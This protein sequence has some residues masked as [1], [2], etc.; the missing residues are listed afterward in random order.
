MMVYYAIFIEI[1]ISM[2]FYS[3]IGQSNDF[4]F[5]T[6]LP[7]YRP[8][9]SKASDGYGYYMAIKIRVNSQVASKL[10]KF[11]ENGQIVWEKVLAIEK[12]DLLPVKL[13]SPPNDGVVLISHV[14][15][16]FHEKFAYVTKYDKNGHF[17]FAKNFKE[18]AQP[19]GI[20]CSDLNIYVF[21]SDIYENGLVLHLSNDG[22]LQTTK[23]LNEINMK[24]HIKDGIVLNNGN[25]ALI[26]DAFSN[27]H[28][29]YC[30]VAILDP[31]ISCVI[32]NDI[33]ESA[34]QSRCHAIS[35]INK[36]SLVVIGTTR[37]ENCEAILLK[38]KMN[39]I[40]D[41]K[42]CVSS[43]NFLKSS[44][45]QDEDYLMGNTWMK[46]ELSSFEF[47]LID[48][49]PNLNVKPP[50]A[51]LL[52]DVP[53]NS[54]MNGLTYISNQALEYIEETTEY[55]NSKGLR[56]LVA[57]EIRYYSPDGVN[58]ILCEPCYFCN[59][60]GKEPCG[61]GLV[62]PLAGEGNA[63]YCEA[64]YAAVDQCLPCVKC[65]PGTYTTENY[66]TACIDCP[67]GTYAQYEG[68]G[69]ACTKC[70]C[71][72]YSGITKL[73][74]VSMCYPCNSGYYSLDG[75]TSSGS[76][77][78]VQ[79]GYYLSASKCG[80]DPCPGG[81]YNP[82]TQRTSS[83]S[84]IQCASG[85][86][87]SPASTFCAQCPPGTYNTSPGSSTCIACVAGTYQPN[88]GSNYMS[89][90]QCPSGC[91]CPNANLANYIEC[92]A[93][94]YQPNTGQQTCLSCPIGTGTSG[95]RATVCIDCTPGTYASGG[96]C[97]N[98]PAGYK[99]PYSKM[100]AATPCDA[101]YYQDQTGKTS[102]IECPVGTFRSSSGGST[103]TPCSKGYYQPATKSTTCIGC[104]AGEYQDVT[105]QTECKICDPGYYSGANA[106][107]QTPCATGHFQD[108][109]KS[110]TCK[111]C[112]PGEYQDLTGQTSCK[113]CD[114]GSWSG[115]NYATCTPCA[116]GYYEDTP[117][118]TA[119]KACSIGYYQDT[120]GQI[121]CKI[122]P[123][124]R[125]TAV[126]ATQLCTPCSA[127]FFEDLEGSIGCR[128]CDAGTYT[129]ITG[130]TVC[131][132]CAVGTSQPLTGKNICPPCAAG[133]YQ[134][135]IMSTSCI[136]CE[137]GK[138]QPLTG[139]TSCDD[140]IAGKYQDV[141]G[142]ASCKSCPAGKY[143]DLTG[144]TDCK[145]CDPGSYSNLDA[146]TCT[147]CAA[148]YYQDQAGKSSCIICP[149]GTYQP[150]TGK[151]SCI[152]C[153]AGT[154]NSLTGRTAL[155][156]CTDCLAGTYSLEGAGTCTPCAT[157]YYQPDIGKTSCIECPVGKQRTTTGGAICSDCPAGYYADTI[158]TSNCK[159]CS[160]GTY[161]DLTGQ[162]GCKQCEVAKYQS[163]TGQSTCIVC[164]AGTYEDTLGSPLC[165]NCP[166]GQF[167]DQT[168][169]TAC[170]LC[171]VGYSQ[172]LTGKT[173]C[174][175]CAAG[176]Y[177]DLTGQ[178][179]CKP[180][181]AGKV[182]PL[183][184]QTSCDECPIAYY[185]DQTGKT[186]CVI[187]PAGKF[188]DQTGQA[189]CKDCSPGYY[190]G[191]GATICLICPI[192]TYTGAGVGS[193]IQCPQGTYNPLEGQGACAKCPAGQYNSNTGSIDVAD[194]Q[195]CGI[196]TYAPE[197][198]G[199]CIA[200]DPGTYQ[201]NTAQGSCLPCDA[202]Y[203]Q[204]LSGKTDCIIC[205]S[206]YKCPTTGVANAIPCPAGTYQPQTGKLSCIDCPAGKY[207]GTT[208]NTGCTDCAVG[209]YT[210]VIGQAT[211]KACPAGKY[212]DAT[213]QS[214][215]KD[216]DV[217]YYQNSEH[218][219]ACII[220][221]VGSYADTV[222][223]AN[224]KLCSAG[225]Y[226]DQTGKTSCTQCGIGYYQPD[227]GK[228]S[229]IVCSAG[230]YQDQ[231]GKESCTQCP[232]G[233][234]Q[235]LT[236]KSS[237]DLCPVAYYQDL[238]G[239]TA[240]K[241]CPAGQFQDLEGQSACKNC[242][243]GYTSLEG[244]TTCVKCLPGTY[245]A[246]GDGA[247]T[248]CPTGT[249]QTLDGQSSC[250]K[251]PAGTANPNQQSSSP[252]A[253][254][255]CLAGNYAPEASA[256]CLPCEAGTYQPDPAKGTCIDCEAGTYQDQTGK[257][258]CIDC[259]IGSKCPTK[260]INHTPCPAG[261]IQ[262]EAKKD[263]CID[264]PIGK[265]I[266][267]AGQTACQSC[268][269][270]Y[271]A[272][273]PGLAAC[274]ACDP[275]TFQDLQEQSTCNKC[276]LGKE[277]PLP[278]LTGCT[279][280]AVGYYADAEGT[281]TCKACPAGSYQDATGKSSCIPCTIGKSQPLT[282][283][284]S[285]SDCAIGY[286]QDEEGKAN[287]KACPAGKIQTL[288]GQSTCED[289]PVGYYQDLTGQTTCKICVAG[290]Y[291]DQPA[292]AIC[293]DCDP[294]YFNTGT[295]L[296]SCTKCSI[297]YYQ[298]LPG[299]TS[300]IICP[301]G[302]YGD[303]EGLPTCPPCP[304][305]TVQPLTGQQTCND[306]AAGSYA[307][308]GT[309]TCQTCPVG[310]AQPDPVK[311][312]CNDCPAGYYQDLTGQLTCKSCAIG[313][314]QPTPKQTTC[315]QCG[316]GTYTPAAGTPSCI[317][318]DAGSYQNQPGKSSCT[319]CLAGYY[320]ANA[321]SSS[322]TKCPLGKYSEAPGWTSCKVPD[323]GWIIKPNRDG[324]L[325]KGLFP[326][327]A[328]YTADPISK[329]C[330][331]SS[332][333]VIKP[334]TLSCKEAIRTLCCT[335]ATKKTGVDCNYA[336][337]TESLTDPMKDNYCKACPFMDQ[338]KC[339]VNGLCWDETT[340]TTNELSTYPLTFTQACIDA[341][342]SFCIP[343]FTANLN[344]VECSLFAAT[345][346][347]VIS[348]AA[349]TDGWTTFK[350]TISKKLPSVLPDC[351]TL[352]DTTFTPQLG[353]ISIACTR[354]TDSIIA[355]TIGDSESKVIKIK[356]SSNFKD[357][358]GVNIPAKELLITPASGSYEVLTVSGKILD[359]CVDATITSAITDKYYP[360]AIKEQYWD[361]QYLDNAGVPSETLSRF[362]TIGNFNKTEIT[363]PSQDLIPGKAIKIRSRLTNA[364]DYETVA[365]W[366]TI[367]IPLISE[368]RIHCGPCQLNDRTKCAYL[369]G[370]CWTNYNDISVTRPILSTDCKRLMAPICYPILLANKNDPQCKDFV[371]I[372]DLDAMKIKPLLLYVAFSTT[373]KSVI[374]KFNAQIKQTNPIDYSLAFD[375]ETLKW[376]PEPLTCTWLNSTSLAVRY[377]P[378]KGAM[379]KFTI[380][381]DSFFY[382]YE[383]AIQSVDTTTLRVHKPA[384][385]VDIDLQSLSDVSECDNIDVFAILKAATLYRLVFRWDI[386]Y[387]APV[388]DPLYVKAK[389]YFEKYRNYSS[390]S[391]I[392]I[393]SS[394]IRKDLNITIKM[395]AKAADVFSGEKLTTKIIRVHASVPK[396]KFLSKAASVL[397]IDG[398]K[399]TNMP[400]E[401]DSTKCG[402]AADT[403]TDLMNIVI[404]FSVA[405]G[406]DLGNINR[407]TNDELTLIKTLNNDFAS[408]HRIYVGIPKGFKYFKYYNIT[409]SVKDTQSNIANI[410]KI[411]IYF[412][413]PSIQAIITSPGYLINILQDVT[414]I[415]SN[416]IIPEQG[417]D[418]ITFS[419]KC[420]T[421]EPIQA[422]IVCTCPFFID[423][424]AKSKN[425]VID[426]AKLRS[427]CRYIFSLAL[428]A[429]S[430]E[431]VRYSNDQ[432]E[433]IAYDGPTEIIKDRIIEPFVTL[434]NETYLTF[435]PSSASNVLLDQIKYQWN[436]VEINSLSPA[437]T[438]NMT[439]KGN[440]T[441]AFFQS[442]GIAVD[443]SIKS[444]DTANI[445]SD[446]NMMIKF[447]GMTPK[448]LT[449]LNE[450]VLGLD[451]S[452][453]AALS[454]YTFGI[455][456]NGMSA[457]T[458][459]FM[460]ITT[461]PAPRQRVFTVTPQ[462]GI[463]F[464]TTFLLTWTMTST[465][466]VDN[467]EYQ[468]FTRNCP[469]SQ[470]TLS[471]LT[472]KIYQSNSFSTLLAP[473]FKTCNESVEI[474]L[475]V[476]EY[477]YFID[478]STTVQISEP[479]EPIQQILTSQIEK[480]T[481][482]KDLTV[483]Q[484]ITIMAG[485]SS[486]K[487]AEATTESQKVVQTIL[488]EI[489]DIGNQTT[490]LM[491]MQ[492]KDQ[493]EFLATSTEI[494]SNL[495]INEQINFDFDMA[496]SIGTQV[497]S[498]LTKVKTIESGTYI[499]PSAV[500]AL[501]GI[502][503]I[504]TRLQKQDNFTSSIQQA[505]NKISD[506]KLKEMI[507]GSIGF[508]AT[509]PSLE[510][511]VYKKFLQN[512]K[513][514]SL[515]LETVHGTNI[516]ISQNIV[517]FY[518]T[519]INS[520]IKGTPAIGASV[521]STMFNPYKNIKAN[522]KII[523]DSISAGLLPNI[524]NDT[525]KRIYD[526][527]RQGKLNDTINMEEIYMPVVQLKL[528]PFVKLNNGS[529]IE[530]NF[531]SPINDLPSGEQ[532]SFSILIPENTDNDV[533]SLQR[534]LLFGKN[535]KRITDDLNNTLMIPI[536]YEHKDEEW[537]NQ[538]CSM[539]PAQFGDTNLKMNCTHMGKKNI[540][541]NN[542]FSVTVDITKDVL[543]VI[544]KGNYEQLVNFAALTQWN[545]RTG[546]AYATVGVIAVIVITTLAALY[547]FD[548]NALYEIKRKCLLS[549]IMP[550]KPV[551][552]TSIFAKIMQF[553][554]KLRKKGTGNYAKQ[555]QKTVTADQKYAKK[556]SG[557]IRG[558]HSETNLISYIPEG[559]KRSDGFTKLNREEKQVLIDTLE[560][561]HQCIALYDEKETDEIM[562]NELTHNKVLNRVTNAYIDNMM[563][564]EEVTFWTIVKNEHEFLNAI[565]R[566]EL[567]TP[568]PS[569]FLIFVSII[570]GELFT[571]GYFFDSSTDTSIS[572][573]S[574]EFIGKA[575][576]MSIAA[577]VLMIPLK[578][579][580]SVFMTG[581]ELK[582]GMTR[583]EVMKSEKNAPLFK[584]I[585][586][587]FGAVWI[588]G[589]LYGIFMYMVAFPGY[590]LN[591]WM[592]SFGMSTFSELFLMSTLKVLVKSGIGFILM[593]ICRTKV[594]MTT[595]GI[596]AGRI[597]DFILKWL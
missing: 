537:S 560:M 468:L 15:N 542:A 388:D 573:N 226:Q 463:G 11:D 351:K 369:S 461:P 140:C 35:Q 389:E 242:D 429:S 595:A 54:L 447:S 311:G 323:P 321:G 384:A 549:K 462:S 328:A 74:D 464:N 195:D 33:R 562:V 455:T 192:G 361:V 359:K 465:V 296:T 427:Y 572:D 107:A 482:N 189:V 87:T 199:T 297:S 194:C 320:Q 327:M 538:N 56:L 439:I 486:I 39:C 249:Y 508:E 251:C 48:M 98:C 239:Q 103:C 172:P 416:S 593:M 445:T 381:A 326:N 385:V 580:I 343:K 414:L 519:L 561:F 114:P 49:T 128:P 18:L 444:K 325:F 229:C 84:C 339:P 470:N 121:E 79:A 131:L 474:I 378:E 566:P 89:C 55:D 237:C 330:F 425:L 504:A 294:G 454:T 94:T 291:A 20:F 569:K 23:R 497:D 273:I 268:D 295:G 597:I 252:T 588:I 528:T 506:M 266:G 396:I 60:N 206:G 132:E 492:P 371:A 418:L 256:N 428:T 37:A 491:T 352:L 448:I 345:C 413:K 554:R 386:E 441:Y 28:L 531:I 576:I 169:Q 423:S 259:P 215:C 160:A 551:K 524:K 185:Q 46:S 292:Q 509:S 92:L 170:K 582:E 224:C 76:C 154:K 344:D 587:I 285:C 167:Q 545:E 85:Y 518:R 261:S 2:I 391:A 213:G 133:S 452:S 100:T 564:Q 32:S 139:K 270:G 230:T 483:D 422:N 52:K 368:G 141:T 487:I 179:N 307:P 319:Q 469:G 102:C 348:S 260:S 186:T 34:S 495:A 135:Q 16:E 357:T 394:L 233:K 73:T 125:Y 567:K 217:G 377:D 104:L 184:G 65:P 360:E 174:V 110:S 31:M 315:V 198:T 477:D 410:D 510:L 221:P 134:D 466:Q 571:T 178:A 393:P 342:G 318:C 9:A 596:I 586:N 17:Q 25:I 113:I 449:S 70:P 124:G 44:L 158:A 164:P 279:D 82:S 365:N 257:T 341:V 262:P 122:C 375:P 66:E 255:Q 258:S 552:Q 309:T 540:D 142:Q 520:T 523:P 152:P 367:V 440:F 191:A 363:I 50:N 379:E 409:A 526:D 553:Y 234:I 592:T 558:N 516:E 502:A 80:A 246:A 188:N 105:G 499:I 51:I 248:P 123:A 30:F 209:Y 218:M 478:V 458:F 336:L 64:G 284:T 514:G 434:S 525:V 93:G 293:K 322:C 108:V 19:M 38:Y 557:S 450:P 282:G 424:V 7:D 210:D 72:T 498:Y 472:T 313:Y 493:V 155:T 29:I 265:F 236:T 62:C 81:T 136:P 281:A 306:C 161:Q 288:T 585:G 488:N 40:L 193:C 300:C 374:L 91:K 590:A 387:S 287:C 312:S 364:F 109:A 190:S 475:R 408:L 484:K 579:F 541:M 529:E 399:T 231:L 253:C 88:Y 269:V 118:S 513:N 271:Y 353:L 301:A 177:Q 201:P 22:S 112:N 59:V 559:K 308:G 435:E 240:C 335:G 250:T 235:P 175:I 45:I 53:F 275:G 274:K 324:Q 340:W 205:P 310:T 577:T 68:T 204:D 527:L 411:I 438:E 490:L 211:C 219:T 333:K 546:I 346:G 216:C 267:T 166:A 362:T 337:E 403:S 358:C 150:D 119:C 272:D 4:K 202:G 437:N 443:T 43:K 436:I 6:Q 535:M 442:L 459:E 578:I 58:C 171:D 446:P 317:P 583:E 404:S 69:P 522:T 355:F 115:L 398:S 116:K 86:Y 168:G 120:T 96:L 151:T 380:L 138:S 223:T 228:T 247:C 536:Y 77:N 521:Y 117:G 489:S 591:N 299:K 547:I 415:G 197:G 183:T 75:S 290:K 182:Q 203:Y 372:Y 570:V 500:A 200:C 453:L 430:S 338:T 395:T 264:C 421:A 303:A 280:C 225:S 148:G 238:P 227:T 8:L 501:S 180:C 539:R 147:P 329:T 26:G 419:W 214:S 366:I 156:V 505:L 207:I 277:Q 402:F 496:K 485:L 5:E 556:A 263:V 90:Q 99:C 10:Q 507:I 350:I 222:G 27:E 97:V 126:T 244:S 101:G 594:M 432:I 286:Y 349:Y 401:I 400:I 63:G 331:D 376:L 480:M 314:A 129:S 106:P 334:F 460:K 589:C 503:D 220:C 232:A 565:M 111:S 405:T 163:S 127:G 278:H 543:K 382:D 467:A 373:G 392:S 512:S 21:G 420:K 426:K 581:A 397:E 146:A 451:K 457:P 165:K 159:A 3:V 347:A 471:P 42:L 417:Q 456:I 407:I 36:E 145:D 67:E 95:N 157:G 515:I 544:A 563:W 473:G 517:S 479:Q 61:V 316:L 212:Q 1:C 130:Q 162:T 153:P 476:F 494:L 57:C 584:M 187:C 383:Y 481:Q 181:E 354:E 550:P 78:M 13:A 356:P 47:N 305:G 12:A 241:K 71:G 548:V 412:V 283:K 575:V 14:I 431:S 245:A 41:W 173:A 574:S 555:S 24:S 144:Q 243:P 406:T 304:P 83:S 289:C 332:Y 370:I 511:S 433:F 533:N 176:T 276:P 298:N 568:R 137:V 534:R 149:A 196:G 390:I 143:Q 208:G 302:T 254:T 530:T 532:I